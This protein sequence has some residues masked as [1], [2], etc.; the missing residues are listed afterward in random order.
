MKYGLE[1]LKLFRQ[2]FRVTDV[3]TNMGNSDGLKRWI[4]VTTKSGGIYPD[5]LKGGGE[6]A[7]QKSAPPDDNSLA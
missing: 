1:T 3:A 6:I 7:T 5:F 4:G 2:G